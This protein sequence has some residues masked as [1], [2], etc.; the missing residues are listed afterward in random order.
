MY[1]YVY[2][3]IYMYVY[4]CILGHCMNQCKKVKIFK[5]HPFHVVMQDKTY[6][7]NRFM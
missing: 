2:N 4:V 6:P 1:M 3:Y 5:V 7:K